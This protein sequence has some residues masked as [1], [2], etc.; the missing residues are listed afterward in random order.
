[1]DDVEA[2]RL[3]VAGDARG[4]EALFRKHY[5]RVVATCRGYSA[6]GSGEAEDAAQDAF[7][8][9][10]RALPSLREPQHFGRWVLTI[11]HNR[12]RTLSSR[13]GRRAEAMR[14]YLEEVRLMVSHTPER[15]TLTIRQ[16]LDV[17]DDERM[18]RVAA[19]YWVEGYT[20]GEISKEVGIPISTVT[21]WMSR[22]AS[23]VR[24]KL[25]ADTLDKKS[26]T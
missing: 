25:L 11:A 13:Q 26:K 22:L 2:V 15:E 6:L 14:T 9:A 19:M 10:F 7:V 8:R 21:T 4:T 17:I 18:K 24:A 1:L 23:R 12:C 16:V 3:A 20:S 5:A